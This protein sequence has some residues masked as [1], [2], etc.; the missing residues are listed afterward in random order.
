[1]LHC[2]DRRL[3]Y[4]FY[5]SVRCLINGILTL[6]IVD[7]LRDNYKGLLFR[8]ESKEVNS[9]PNTGK[10]CFYTEDSKG[11]QH[12]YCTPRRQSK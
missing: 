1:M 7:K 6:S 5:K 4:H 12:L 11:Q 3:S 2:E 10:R 9:S 8:K